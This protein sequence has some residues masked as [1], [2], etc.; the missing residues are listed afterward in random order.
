LEAPTV[1]EYWSFPAHELV[2]TTLSGDH[3]FP[4]SNVKMIGISK[5]HL[6]TQFLKLE[7]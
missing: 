7:G 2:Q 6:G 5:N 4:G 3:L 1:R